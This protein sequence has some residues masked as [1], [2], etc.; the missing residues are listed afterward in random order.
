METSLPIIGTWELESS[1]R[2]IHGFRICRPDEFDKFL[3]LDE[4]W[5]IYWRTLEC[6]LNFNITYDSTRYLKRDSNIV[7]MLDD[8]RFK[9]FVI[10]VG[11]KEIKVHKN[12]LAVA[13]PVFSTMLQP[14]YKEFQ[15]SRVTIKDFDYD[16]VIEAV[17]LIYTG[18]F[19]PNF[20]LTMLLN[21]Y[22]F[23]DKYG[24]KQTVR[25]IVKMKL[26]NVNRF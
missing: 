23:A 25:T 6:K 16:T 15:E 8:D 19:N 11:D 9:D 13:S 26:F 17:N 3:R 5:P 12:V 7:A 24:L 22:R 4:S 2:G 10:C 1:G 18:L 20:P 21:L 14:H